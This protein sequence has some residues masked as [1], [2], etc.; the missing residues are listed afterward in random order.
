[1]VLCKIKITVGLGLD[2]GVQG[3]GQ[4]IY[5]EQKRALILQ[6]SVFL[7]SFKMPQKDVRGAYVCP[8]SEPPSL[9]GRRRLYISSRL[10]RPS[11]GLPSHRCVQPCLHTSRDRELTTSQDGCLVFWGARSIL[12]EAEIFPLPRAFPFVSFL[13]TLAFIATHFPSRLALLLTF[14]P[15]IFCHFALPVPAFLCSPVLLPSSPSAQLS[16][17]VSVAHQFLSPS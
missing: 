2:L 14:S 15:R 5:I 11:L 9:G 16:P 17:G 4:S 12:V 3:Q 13:I 8:L 10:H 7:H 6:F 1:M